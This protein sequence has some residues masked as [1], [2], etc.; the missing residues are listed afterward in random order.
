MDTISDL[1]SFGTVTVGLPTRHRLV[2]V[3]LDHERRLIMDALFLLLVIVAIALGIVGVVVVKGLLYLLIIGIV[4][5]LGALILGG[6]PGR[7]R[8]R[9]SA[10]S[11]VICRGDYFCPDC[12]F[13]STRG[14]PS[15]GI[16]VSH[17][18]YFSSG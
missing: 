11:G 6:G 15:L 17:L 16:C 7:K 13:P 4:M 14:W 18:C 12:S 3:S 10:P 5:F 2:F 8:L 1:P 9:L